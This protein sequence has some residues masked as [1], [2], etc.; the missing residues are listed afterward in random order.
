V[1]GIHDMGGMQGF[2]AVPYEPGEPVFQEDWHRK[3]FAFGAFAARLSGTNQPAF[4]HAIERVP[5]N[6]YLADGYYGRW[7]RGTE[8]LLVDSGVLA[9]GEVDARARRLRGEDVP[10]P[11]APTPS[12]PDY[13]ATGPGALRQVEA[14]ARFAVGDRVRAR[15]VHPTGHTRLPRYVRGCTGMVER[16]QPAHVLPDTHAHFR[17]EEPQHVYGVVFPS[18]ELW[19]PEGEDF[20]LHIDLSESYLEA[21]S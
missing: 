10:D 19:G 17:G 11:P 4:R 14:A 5:P 6:D 21:A 7:L 9:P 18:S 2:G 1:D 13:E 12:K 16:I 20:T 8:L 15:D 3:V